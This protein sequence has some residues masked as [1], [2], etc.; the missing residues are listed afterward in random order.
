MFYNT[1]VGVVN[2]E[3]ARLGP[4]ANPSTMSYY[5]RIYNQTSVLVRFKTKI[6]YFYF[7]KTL[8]PT[9]VHVG[10]VFSGRRI[11]SRLIISFPGANPT[12]FEFTTTTPAL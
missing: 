8:Q 10:V 9:T 4:G 11:G 5:A 7:R 3:V 6:I 2:L 1:G 12:T